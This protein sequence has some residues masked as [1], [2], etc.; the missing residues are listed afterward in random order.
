MAN[1]KHIISETV[2]RQ[3]GKYPAMNRFIDLHKIDKKEHP[4]SDRDQ[5]DDVETKKDKSRPADKETVHES[6]ED[7][8]KAVKDGMSKR[9]AIRKFKVDGK[10]LDAA[11]PKNSFF[12][13]R[14]HE[15]SIRSGQMELGDG[16]TVKV[17]GTT[18][19]LLNDL[20]GQLDAKNKK[21]ML[22]TLAKNKKEF[23]HVVAFAKETGA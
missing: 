5:F 12:E 2:R 19:N 11:L 15:A 10:Q 14:L 16:T 13:W 23:D 9:D 3:R 18:A 7:A 8:V 6:I 21:I 4:V 22:Q 20:L 17:D 1:I